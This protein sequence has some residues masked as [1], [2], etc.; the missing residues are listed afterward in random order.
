MNL[1]SCPQ[2]HSLGSIIIIILQLRQLRACRGSYSSRLL[3]ITECVCKNHHSSGIFWMFVVNNAYDASFLPSSLYP[4]WRHFLKVVHSID[5]PEEQHIVSGCKLYVN[6]LHHN[7]QTT[8]IVVLHMWLVQQFNYGGS[9]YT[10]H[11][12]LQS[13]RTILSWLRQDEAQLVE[14][15]KREEN[16]E[17]G[18][19]N[20]KDATKCRGWLMQ[21]K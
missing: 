2:I 14:I 11:A 17:R 20:W 8:Q 16:S 6:L 18:S 12:S 10:F 15:I 13:W 9:M 19:A 3:V 5:F 7:A 21:K 4:Y 1:H